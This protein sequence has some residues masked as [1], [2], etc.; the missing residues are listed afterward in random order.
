M[1]IVCTRKASLKKLKNES[2][3]LHIGCRV[4]VVVKLG[5]KTG[6]SID[7]CYTLPLHCWHFSSDLS[8]LLLV[9][10]ILLQ[11]GALC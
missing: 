5:I 4:D 8:Q 10:R 9:I 3:V 1:T 11:I 7:H 6:C 2:V